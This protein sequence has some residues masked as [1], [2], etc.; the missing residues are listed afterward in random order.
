MKI[1]IIQA[2]ANHNECGGTSRFIHKRAFVHKTAAEA[3]APEFGK[4]IEADSSQ[5][6]T[7]ANVKTMVN[8]LELVE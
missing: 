5:L 8:E 7:Y 2:T 3:F 6:L 4:S 1:Y